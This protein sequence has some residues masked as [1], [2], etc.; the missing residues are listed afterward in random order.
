[1]GAVEEH[2]EPTEEPEEPSRKC[3]RPEAHSLATVGLAPGDRLEVCW[4]LELADSEEPQP[5]W[6]G[7]VVNLAEDEDGLSYTLGYEAA[8]GFEAE[9]RRVV[10]CVDGTLWDS[11]LREILDWR[12]EGEWGAVPEDEE[13]EEGSGE[14]VLQIGASVKSRFQGGE[15]HAGSIAARHADGTFDVLYEDAVMEENVPREMIELVEITP[16]V[17]AAIDQGRENVAAESINDFFDLFVNSLTSGAKFA[18]LSAEKQAIASE[19]VRALK[20]HFESELVALREQRGRGAQVTGEDIQTLLPRVM[21]RAT[22]AA[23]S[24]A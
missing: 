10:F 16:T 6:W 14:G 5:V 13:D 9:D 18:S 24:A 19:R 17:Q 8:H 7:A 2:T 20:P 1:M 3:A 11:S 23:Q 12:P 4:Q 22:Q 15:F 21:A